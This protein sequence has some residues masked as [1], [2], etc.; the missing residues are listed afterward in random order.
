MLYVK[1]P[2]QRSNSA[3]VL[4]QRNAAGVLQQQ[5]NATSP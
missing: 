3:V 5:R 4:Q 1:E 2:Q